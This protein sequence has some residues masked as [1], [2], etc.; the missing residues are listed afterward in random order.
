MIYVNGRWG[1]GT[2]VI[3]EVVRR[4]GFYMGEHNTG[5]DGRC[6]YGIV[7]DN[8]T[9]AGLRADD[10]LKVKAGLRQLRMEA[11][12]RQVEPGL[13]CP[14]LLVRPLLWEVVEEEC[15]PRAALW[16]TRES[17]PEEAYTMHVDY[18]DAANRGFWALKRR[19]DMKNVPGLIVPFEAMV[20]DPCMAIEAIAGFLG[21]D[22][23][24]STKA[25]VDP[26][27]MRCPV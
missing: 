15:P 1:N 7:E 2:S 10:K 11:H 24:Y 27:W 16:V 23:D 14:W 13:K 8:L 22:P 5:N 4:H 9:L 3:A 19:W 20:K 25:V 21:V 26:N 18:A 12:A 17:K 6:K